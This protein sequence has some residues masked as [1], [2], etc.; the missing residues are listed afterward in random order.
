MAWYNH[1][2]SWPLKGHS[3][4]G[5][6]SLR[7]II[8]DS[9]RDVG[10]TIEMSFFTADAFSAEVLVYSQEPGQRAEE[11]AEIT[12]LEA[13]CSHLKSFLLMQHDKETLRSPL[14]T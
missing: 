5:F 7:L 13:G 10:N 1:I 3:V 6:I 12:Q 8:V 9:A 14:L 11:W 4:I 2:F